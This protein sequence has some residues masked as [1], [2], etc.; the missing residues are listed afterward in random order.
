MKEIIFTLV[1]EEPL[2]ITSGSAESMAHESLAYIPGN[3][4]LGALATVWKMENPG[5]IPDR[6]PEF[7]NLFLREKVFFGHAYPLCGQDATIP[8]PRCLIRIK[9]EPDL[10]AIDDDNITGAVHNLLHFEGEES[11]EEKLA[12]RNHDKKKNVKSQKLESGFISRQSFRRPRHRR[13]NNIHVAL[14]EQRSALPS[15]LFA[16]NAIAP[17]E[18]LRSSILAE[19][20]MVNALERV[21]S[22]AKNLR[23]GHSRSAGYGLVSAAFELADY[24]EPALLEHN[25][26]TLFLVSQYIPSPSWEFPLQNLLKKIEKECGAKPDEEKVFADYCEIHGFNGLWRKSR[27][28][29][30][31]LNMGSVIRLS[32]PQKVKLPGSLRLGGDTRE[33]YGRIICNPD[34]LQKDIIRPSDPNYKNSRTCEPL[35]SAAMPIVKLLRQRA[36]DRLAVEQ[37]ANWINLGPWKD[38]LAHIGTSPRPTPSQRARLLSITVAQFE[39]LLE[40]SQGGQWKETICKS[41]FSHQKEYLDKTIRQLLDVNCFL[42]SFP[43]MLLE[44]PGPEAS[45]AECE[46]FGRKAHKIFLRDLVSTWGKISRKQKQE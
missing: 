12:E 18:R 33:G 31:A 3:M 5:L 21:L 8:L 43:A 17:G 19:N 14:G 36:L 37:A 2:V 7:Q 13:L 16:Y 11:F 38:F 40:K 25:K 29:R 32:F 46:D 42:K 4:I 41:P 27:D 44:L 22:R 24:P 26:F 15:Q 9:G 35:D 30:S 28:S 6:S 10:P 39:E 20:D 34:F 23:V 1:A 45:K